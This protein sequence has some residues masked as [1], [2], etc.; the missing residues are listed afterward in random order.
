VNGINTVTIRAR[1]EAGNVG[2]RQIVV[3]ALIP[4][5]ALGNQRNID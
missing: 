2:T 5:S 4:N 1:D 3:K